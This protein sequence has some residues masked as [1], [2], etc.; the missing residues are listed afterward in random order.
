MNNPVK[1]WR[2]AFR[3]GWVSGSVAS[4]LSTI[5]LSMLGKAELDKSA[6]PV[7]GPS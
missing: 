2:E 1:S 5:S 6:A 4:V 7:N 3:N